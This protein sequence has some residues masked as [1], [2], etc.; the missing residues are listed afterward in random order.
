MAG[1]SESVQARLCTALSTQIIIFRPDDF[2]PGLRERWQG[3]IQGVRRHGESFPDATARMSEDTA[4]GF[5][6][7]IVDLLVDIAR[8]TGVQ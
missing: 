3:I 2:P 5:I 8:R 1:S 6:D 4:Q 7:E